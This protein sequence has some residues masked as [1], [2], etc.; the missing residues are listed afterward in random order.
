MDSYASNPTA[1]SEGTSVTDGDDDSR[2]GDPPK[3]QLPPRLSVPSPKG[4]EGTG[5][6]SQTFDEPDEM[7]P[8]SPSGTAK[9]APSQLKG[10]ERGRGS[11]ATLKVNTTAA[12]GDDG[13]VL[14]ES[15]TSD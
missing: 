11:G 9:D 13:G 2:R 12:G 7:E 14:V 1:T 10:E 3:L 8:A 5:D 4:K 15:P 6:E